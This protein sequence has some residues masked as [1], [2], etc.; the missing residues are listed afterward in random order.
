MI[1][2]LATMAATATFVML[3]QSWMAMSSLQDR[4]RGAHTTSCSDENDCTRRD[5]IAQQMVAESAAASV[6]LTY[7][8]LM[9]SGLGAGLIGWTL[10]ATRRAT[11]AAVESAVAARQ[12]VEDAQKAHQQQLRAYLIVEAEKIE[13]L[14]DRERVR[15]WIKIINQGSTPAYTVA[16]VG[17]VEL[18][19]APFAAIEVPVDQIEDDY[20]TIIAGHGRD[21][22]RA[23]SAEF[24]LLPGAA[25]EV[26]RGRLVLALSGTVQYRDIFGHL[27][28][29]TF[30]HR[31]SGDPAVGYHQTKGL[32][33][34]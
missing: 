3:V 19:S 1:A 9:L 33:A 34:T 8:S 24:S 12:S 4:L 32:S 6:Q 10:M 23:F 20:T 15:I 7:V 14:A 27:H 29:I 18:V 13:R 16:S 17:R 21:R 26:K 2:A 28:H 5:L 11:A 31:W 30:C 25:A 22:K